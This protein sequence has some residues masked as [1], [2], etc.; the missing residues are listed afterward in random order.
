MED[1]P[2]YYVRVTPDTALLFDAET[3]DLVGNVGAVIGT[4]NRPTGTWSY[5]LGRLDMNWRAGHELKTAVHT[6]QGR[7]SRS[8]LADRQRWA[9]ES[10]AMIESSSRL[11]DQVL[12]ALVRLKA[13]VDAQAAERT[14][15]Q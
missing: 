2:V 10:K 11:A 4:G 15:V 12:Y 5:R 8:T 1:H 7:Y 13:F 3:L 14:F 6:A 9:A